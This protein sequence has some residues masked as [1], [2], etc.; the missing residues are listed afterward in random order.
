MRL[1]KILLNFGLLKLSVGRPSEI[2][3]QDENVSVLTNDCD[4][5]AGEIFWKADGKCYKIGQRGP[6]KE[7][8]ILS[9]RSK[10]IPECSPTSVSIKKTVP[11]LSKTTAVQIE[12]NN[13]TSTNPVCE[14][15]TIAWSDGQ[16]YQLASTGPCSTGQ[17][18][19]LDSIV[20]GKPRATCQD[21]KCGAD[22]VWWAEN[23][24]CVSLHSGDGEVKL[25]T[26]LESACAEGEIILITPYGDGICAFSDSK[27]L[28]VRLFE[29]I[30]DNYA[31][32]GNC[33]LDETGKCRILTWRN[34]G[35][36]EAEA[37]EDSSKSQE[38]IDLITWLE[39][40]K[41][42][43]DDLCEETE[44]ATASFAVD[45]FIDIAVKNATEEGV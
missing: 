41:K 4:I 35:K 25:K 12:S 32:K 23:C 36:R 24:T 29:R 42:P 8:E 7:N 21:R 27:E 18:L 39:Q 14:G 33:I 5:V 9:V 30:P 2:F 28:S 38:L 17:W 6:C 31:T 40:F 37:K 16:C 45:D 20:N 15:D 22:H 19:V 3:F 34:R 1:L 44:T 11:L 10:R 43:N 26:G 13:V